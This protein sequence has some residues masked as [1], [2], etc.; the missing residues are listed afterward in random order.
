[1]IGTEDDEQ[2]LH[3]PALQSIAGFSKMLAWLIAILAIIGIFI[4]LA[5]LASSGIILL[6]G[7][8][9]GG[10]IGFITLLAASE[11]I[12]LSIDIEKNTRIVASNIT[13]ENKK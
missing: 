5:N 12:K 9:I 6:L 2:K 13:K 8:L 11:M 7:S 3:Y 4:G 1:M 10:G